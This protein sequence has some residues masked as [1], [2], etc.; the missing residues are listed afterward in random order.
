M[1]LMHWNDGLKIYMSVPYNFYNKNYSK[2]LRQFYLT[3]NGGNSDLNYI[4]GFFYLLKIHNVKKYR[5]S[6]FFQN[7]INESVL[8]KERLKEITYPSKLVIKNF[9][10]T[11]NESSE[12]NH[13]FRLQNNTE[14]I[15]YNCKFLDQKR[16][17]R[18]LKCK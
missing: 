2:G 5:V 6:N 8:F 13:Y 9:K 18:I 14:N 1:S 4:E 11:I 12:N 15:P 17:V 10:K 16:F 7:E 3:D